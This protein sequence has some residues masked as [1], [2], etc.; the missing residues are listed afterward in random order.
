M[1][2]NQPL[3]LNAGMQPLLPRRVLAWLAVS[4]ASRRGAATGTPAWRLTG[5]AGQPLIVAIGGISGHRRIFDVQQPRHG[6]WHELVDPAARST[7]RA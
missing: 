3:P 7:A 5:I 1:I 6:W 4:I 2:K